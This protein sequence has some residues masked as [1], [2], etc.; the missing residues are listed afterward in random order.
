[1]EKIFI[2]KVLENCEHYKGIQAS[3]IMKAMTKIADE[4][5][6]KNEKEPICGFSIKEYNEV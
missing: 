1:M 6:N 5:N 4:I 3:H 2:V